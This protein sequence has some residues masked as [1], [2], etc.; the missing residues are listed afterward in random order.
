MA[1]FFETL[2]RIYRNMKVGLNFVV[3]ER[4]GLF[5]HLINWWKASTSELSVQVQYSYK[6]S[7][8]Q[9]DL[10]VLTT[11]VFVSTPC[12]SR[13]GSQDT[14][15]IDI[16]HNS[17]V[18]VLLGVSASGDRAPPLFAFTG[19]KMVYHEI[20]LGSVRILDSLTNYLPLHAMASMRKGTKE[21]TQ[22]TFWVGRRCSSSMPGHSQPDVIKFC[23]C[24]MVTEP[25]WHKLYSNCLVP[26]ESSC[27]LCQHTRL[28]KPAFR[29]GCIFFIQNC[30]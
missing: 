8:A 17:L 26:Q 2:H 30:T 28:V 11:A 22:E 6:S 25:T 7:T 9:R 10:W 13:R 1:F 16:L 4:G 19:G 24:T 27:M 15:I 21:S 12:I 18:K 3:G 14:I 5:E 29:L 23:S 20:I